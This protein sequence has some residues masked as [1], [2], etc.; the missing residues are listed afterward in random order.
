MIKTV[1]KNYS[2]DIYM[3]WDTMEIS[4]GGYIVRVQ[5]FLVLYDPSRF[6]VRF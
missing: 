4:C 6:S 5:G 2:T 3:N 1:F